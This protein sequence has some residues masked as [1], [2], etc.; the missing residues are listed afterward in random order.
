[1][2]D[3]REAYDSGAS[4]TDNITYGTAYG[5]NLYY[6]ANLYFDGTAEANAGIEL[7]RA[8]SVSLGTATANGSGNWSIYSSVLAEGIHSI[9]AKQTDVAG[10]ISPA[11]GALSVTVDKSA[12][13]APSTAPDLDSASDTGSSSADDITDD[14]TPTFNGTGVE[15]NATI[16]IYIGESSVGSGLADGSGNWSVTTAALAYMV[17][18]ISA[19]ATDVAG[20]IS[21]ASPELSV[22][23]TSTP[24]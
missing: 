24:P 7:F 18:N 12:P 10:N 1:M 5:P 20:S 21:S 15:A 6:D 3:L 8:G 2:P 17:H 4:S 16:T 19:K 14:T 11:S 22:T 9:T 13:G 23:I